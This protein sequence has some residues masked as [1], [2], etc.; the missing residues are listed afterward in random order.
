MT[1]LINRLRE[2]AVAAREEGTATALGDAL[3]F[4][5]AADVAEREIAAQAALARIRKVRDGYADQAKFADV[6]PASYFRE[7]VR[8]IDEAVAK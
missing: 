4:E 5:E 2:R 3:H 6:D 8:R 1:D 7:F